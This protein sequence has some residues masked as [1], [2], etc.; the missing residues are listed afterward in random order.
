[1]S[2]DTAR[3]KLNARLAEL[4]VRYL[5]R[6]ADETVEIRAAAQRFQG[7]ESGA[8]H[9]IERAAHR[10]RG[11]GGMFGFDAVS[12]AASRLELS[13]AGGTDTASQLLSLVDELDVQV[14]AAA[15]ARGQTS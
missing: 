15:Q 6:T 3:Q 4:A 1:M 9:E 7:G 2:D 14:K 10:I 11:S 5:R 13:A 8:L 12:D